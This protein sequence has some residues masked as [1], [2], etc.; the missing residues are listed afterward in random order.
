V[1]DLPLIQAYQFRVLA[2]AVAAG[3]S[4]LN[5]YIDLRSGATPVSPLLGAANINPTQSYSAPAD[6]LGDF[7]NLNEGFDEV[8]AVV[9][10]DTATT[11]GVPT[12]AAYTCDDIT[13]TNAALMDNVTRGS[14]TLT[15]TALTATTDDDK[16]IL[17]DV[18]RATGRFVNIRITRATQNIA[19]NG[20]LA[21]LGKPR[22]YPVQQHTTVYDQK[23][24]Y[25]S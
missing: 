5:Y 1:S 16:L 4:T 7:E 20:V 18:S 9:F 11:G 19:L 14:A 12:V 21:V 17:L 25:E 6:Q 24:A 8:V 22:R 10:L 13:G 3:T 15:S 2:G 23:V